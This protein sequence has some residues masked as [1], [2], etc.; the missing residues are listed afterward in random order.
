MSG[1]RPDLDELL[2]EQIGFLERSSAAYDEGY[3]DEAKR[4]A[5]VVRVLLHDT[6][7]SHSLFEQLP[8]Y[9]IS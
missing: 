1:T 8:T 2:R 7:S 9:N 4:I 5:V 6:Q 3:H